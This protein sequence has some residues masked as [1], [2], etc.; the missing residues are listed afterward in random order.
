M[1]HKDL[2]FNHEVCNRRALFECVLGAPPFAP[3]PSNVELIENVLDSL[4]AS[5]QALIRRSPL[6]HVAWTWN[7]AL[8]RFV[9]Q[10]LPRAWALVGEVGS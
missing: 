3:A 2:A 4:G 5:P 1:S 9:H 6:A 8:G 7:R 10:P